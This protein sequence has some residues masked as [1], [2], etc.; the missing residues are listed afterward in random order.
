MIV[1]PSYVDIGFD[2]ARDVCRYQV[3]CSSSGT[4]TASQN[5]HSGTQ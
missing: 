1:K 2:T 5:C 3:P 4:E